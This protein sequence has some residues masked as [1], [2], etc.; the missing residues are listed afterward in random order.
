ME[1]QRLACLDITVYSRH[2]YTLNAYQRQSQLEIRH[3]MDSAGTGIQWSHGLF[4][5]IFLFYVV[6]ILCTVHTDCSKRYSTL[7]TDI[8]FKFDKHVTYFEYEAEQQLNR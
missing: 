2:R 3:H 7:F 4:A 6:N 5:G 1:I 8:K